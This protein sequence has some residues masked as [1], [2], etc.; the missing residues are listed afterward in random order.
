M[1]K[2]TIIERICIFGGVK[3]TTQHEVMSS[4]TTHIKV[5]SE[6]EGTELISISDFTN[7]AKDGTKYRVYK[8]KEVDLKSLKIG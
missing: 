6:N 7:G 8:G 1:K 2:G 3:T 4:D 5:A